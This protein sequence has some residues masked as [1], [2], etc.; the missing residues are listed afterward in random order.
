MDF[1]KNHGSDGCLRC[2]QAIITFSFDFRSKTGFNSNMAEVPSTRTLALGATAPDF[3]LPDAAGRDFWLSDVRGPAGLV[4][5]FVCNHCPFVLLLADALGRFAEECAAK[6]VGFVAINSN[7]AERYPADAPDKMPAFAQ[8]HGWQFPYLVDADQSVAQAY[9]AA[10]TPDFYLFDR[11]LKLAYC[12]Q[13]DASR[14]G[15]GQQPTGES[16]R[17]AVDAM[18]Q[19]L[20]PLENQSPSTG[21]NIKWKPGNEPAWF[22]AA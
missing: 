10:C 12:G 11:H 14:P 21:C 9:F 1:L 16:L 17:Q 7:N 2:V 15:N 20:A 5:A 22:G 8:Q 18:L 13:F 3:C 4:V 6:G 19:G